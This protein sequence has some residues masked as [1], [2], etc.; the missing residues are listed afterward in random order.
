MKLVRESPPSSWTAMAGGPTTMAMADHT[1]GMFLKDEYRLRSPSFNLQSGQGSSSVGETFSDLPVSGSPRR[2]SDVDLQVGPD[3]LTVDETLIDIVSEGPS[4]ILDVDS[5]VGPGL[6][7][8][9]DNLMGHISKSPTSILDVEPQAGLGPPTDEIPLEHI[10]E[11]PSIDFEARQRHPTI[12]E[13]SRDQ[14]QGLPSLE[15][16]FVV[17]LVTY[18]KQ[19]FSH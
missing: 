13:V 2:V 6:S 14:V 4:K 7:A 17:S 3:P 19:I 12:D 15:V 5:Q 9:D 1:S 11:S 18:M 10:S 16:Y 8:V